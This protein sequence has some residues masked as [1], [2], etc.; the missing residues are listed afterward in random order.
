MVSGGNRGRQKIETN[1]METARVIG[2][3]NFV[4]KWLLSSYRHRIVL[5]CENSFHVSSLF[6]WLSFRSR[7]YWSL[8]CA[9]CYIY[10]IENRDINVG[11]IIKKLRRGM[12]LRAFTL[13]AW[14][15]TSEEW[16]ESHGEGRHGKRLPWTPRYSAHESLKRPGFLQEDTFCSYF[17]Q[18]VKELKNMEMLGRRHMAMVPGIESN[19]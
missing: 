17:S 8:Q 14:A 7:G 18:Q 19:L 15:R 2:K 10:G 3:L 5:P 13:K 16:K 11:K 4:H 9:D 12:S 1:L 6:V